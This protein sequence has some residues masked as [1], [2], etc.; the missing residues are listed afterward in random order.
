MVMGNLYFSNDWNTFRKEVMQIVSAG[1]GYIPIEETAV[2]E[3][4][5]RWSWNNTQLG[6][7]WAKPC[8][9]AILINP[10]NV[11]WEPFNPRRTLLLKDYLEYEEFFKSVDDDIKLCKSST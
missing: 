6:L 4:P 8:V 11:L 10:T 2:H 5:Y 9:R 1:K 7:V 3:N